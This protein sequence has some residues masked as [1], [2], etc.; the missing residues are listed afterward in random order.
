[1]S[2]TTII[3][4]GAACSVLDAKIAQKLGIKPDIN[5]NEC[6]ITADGGRHKPLGKVGDLPINLANVVFG[7]EVLVMNLPNNVL[8]LGMDWLSRYNAQLDLKAK[9]ITITNNNNRIIL[10]L[11]MNES[12]TERKQ[13]YGIT[14]LERFGIGKESKVIYKLT[15]MTDAI[16]EEVI[17]K[18]ADQQVNES[19]N[20]P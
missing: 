13:N 14:D 3:D 5:T 17:K 20:L 9:N 15:N 8:I 4:T 1:M 16:L 2:I 18:Y 12:T 11:H 7:S 10:P 6:I 19:I